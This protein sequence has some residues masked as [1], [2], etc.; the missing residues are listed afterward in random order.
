MDLR[1][2][3]L[4]A[5]PEGGY[6]SSVNRLY[7][8]DG[9]SLEDLIFGRITANAANVLCNGEQRQALGQGEVL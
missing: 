3:R 9:L 6:A 7:R 4:I 5:G 1:S 2:R 8:V